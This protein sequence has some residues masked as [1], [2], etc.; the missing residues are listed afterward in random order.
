MTKQYREI[1]GNKERK[2]G[3]KR[4][5]KRKKKEKEGKRRKKRERGKEGKK[6]EKEGKIE[7]S[8]ANEKR[9]KNEERVSSS[10]PVPE[11]IS[12]SRTLLSEKK[13]P[14]RTITPMEEVQLKAN[15]DVKKKFHTFY[16]QQ[17]H[18]SS[19]SLFE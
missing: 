7:K 15:S 13:K 1:Q 2:R 8:R 3:K 11:D 9:E 14:I 16:F 10:S 18:I 19:H 4:G 5:K 12:I 17:K 6:S